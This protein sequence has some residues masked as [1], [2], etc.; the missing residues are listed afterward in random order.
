MS[1]ITRLTPV[2]HSS[3]TISVDSTFTAK[4]E[5]ETWVTRR[6]EIEPGQYRIFGDKGTVT[7]QLLAI[8][9]Q[10]AFIATY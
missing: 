6:I 10:V 4:S 2:M 7:D 8:V 5:P 9:P 1:T 3:P